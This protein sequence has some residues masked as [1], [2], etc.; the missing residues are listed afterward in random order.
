MSSMSA[1][2]ES[3]AV[4]PLFPRNGEKNEGHDGA[5]NATQQSSAPTPPEKD[6]A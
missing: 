1:T 5:E 3:A 6:G 2:E 4:C